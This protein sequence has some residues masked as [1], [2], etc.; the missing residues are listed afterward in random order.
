M[1]RVTFPDSMV[2]FVARFQ[3]RSTSHRR[4]PNPEPDRNPQ[5]LHKSGSLLCEPAIHYKITLSD[6]QNLGP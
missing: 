4:H 5:S 6:A 2:T 3:A 1:S